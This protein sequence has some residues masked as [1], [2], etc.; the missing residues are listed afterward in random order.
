MRAFTNKDVTLGEN[1]NGYLSGFALKY[2][3]INCTLVNEGNWVVYSD[4]NSY[5]EGLAKRYYSN[6]SYFIGN[7][8][9]SEKQGFGKYIWDD[10]D[11]FIGEWK[12]SIINKGLHFFPDSGNLFDL[13]YTYNNGEENEGNGTL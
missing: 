11:Y 2:T 9:K 10:G 13:E 5:L 12:D 1:Y 8:F 7:F 3:D 6:N 4:G